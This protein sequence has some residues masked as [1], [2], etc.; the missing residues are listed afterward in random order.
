M[1]TTR[2]RFPKAKTIAITSRQ[3]AKILPMDVRPKFSWHESERGHAAL[4]VS[5]ITNGSEWSVDLYSEKYMCVRI[6]GKFSE[7]C[8]SIPSLV[9]YFC[10]VLKVQVGRH[11]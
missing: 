6:A 4:R 11:A 3:I 2:S 10:R 1:K 8:T 7:I 9:L 5:S